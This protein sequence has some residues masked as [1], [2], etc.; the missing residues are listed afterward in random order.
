MR[1]PQ[2]LEQGFGLGRGGAKGEGNVV[3]RSCEVLD[4]GGAQSA[5]AAGDKDVAPGG[6][7]AHA[8][9]RAM[10]SDTFCPPKPNELESACVTLAS[11]ATFGTTSSGMAGSGTL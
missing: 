6:G 7:G 4:D 3:T 1:R 11:R 5:A 10:I 2:F 9:S 8:G